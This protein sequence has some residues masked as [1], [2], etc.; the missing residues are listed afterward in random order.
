MKIALTLPPTAAANGVKG[1]EHSLIRDV[2]R[3]MHVR[4]WRLLVW[5]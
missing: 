1:K 5:Y 4:Q 2:L 3:G